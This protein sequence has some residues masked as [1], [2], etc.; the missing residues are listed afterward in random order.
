VS[1]QV[2][3]N[4]ALARRFF[5][6]V[7]NQGDEAAIER[8]IVLNAAGNDA[9]FGSG[10]EAFRA[11]W[12]KWRAAFPDLH[13][14]VEQVIGEDDM[15]LTRWTLTGTHSAEF[16]GIPATGRRISVQG[17][18]LDRIADGMIVE[19]FDGWD[20]WGVRVQLGLEGTGN[21]EQGTVG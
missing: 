10:R 5:E 7:W 14:A 2:E 18:S 4:K 11:Q 12:R 1:E 13:F 15:V 3:T 20:N 6:E 21:R 9:D 17:M 16:L 19:G 8:Y